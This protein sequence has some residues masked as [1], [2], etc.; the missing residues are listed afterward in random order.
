MNFLKKAWKWFRIK[1]FGKNSRDILEEL[2]DHDESG[3]PDISPFT[4]LTKKLGKTELPEEFKWD[5]ASDKVLR[6]V[7]SDAISDANN[8]FFNYFVWPDGFPEPTEEE[9][10]LAM[11]KLRFLNDPEILDQLFNVYPKPLDPECESLKPMKD[12]DDS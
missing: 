3:K 12:N 10:F 1:I 6:G 5:E 8:W 9:L 2:F 11:A 4:E 7:V